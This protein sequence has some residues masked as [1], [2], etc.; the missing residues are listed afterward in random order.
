MGLLIREM[1]RLVN[2]LREQRDKLEKENK[3][4]EMEMSIMI[5]NQLVRNNYIKEIEEE[6]ERLKEI[7]ESQQRTFTEIK[8]LLKYQIVVK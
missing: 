5:E 3:T 6:N 7:I 8:E 1:E 4:L 2:Q